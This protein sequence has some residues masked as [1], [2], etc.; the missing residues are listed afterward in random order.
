MSEPAPPVTGPVPNPVAEWVASLPPPPFVDATAAPGQSRFAP[1]SPRVAILV[2][3]FAIIGLLLWM[4][5][6]S[7]RPFI[8]GILFVYLSIHRSAGWRVEVC[9]AR[10][11]SSSCMWSRS[12]PS[13]SSSHS[14]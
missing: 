13:S 6:D 9:A 4:A 14:P 11:R 8:L 12:S 7:V 5:R 3:A 1:L 10:W 2:A